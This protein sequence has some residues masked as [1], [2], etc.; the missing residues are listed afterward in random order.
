MK[1][2]NLKRAILASIMAYIASLIVGIIVAI[3]AGINLGET[4]EIPPLLW[5]V[6]SIA[7]IIFAGVFAFW[8]FRS[9]SISPSAKTGLYFGIVMIV[10]GFTLDLIT[11][12]PLLTHEN[13]L[14]PILGYYLAPMFWVTLLLILATTSLIGKYL[15][16][17]KSTLKTI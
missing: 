8:Y 1:N 4:Q 7:A 2:I 14:E 13:P 16:I 9:P 12:L 10:T 17:K 6:G 15:A 3:G 11:L 5:Y